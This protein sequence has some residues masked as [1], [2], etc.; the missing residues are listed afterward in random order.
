[1]SARPEI[2]PVILAGGLGRRLWPLSRPARPKPFIKISF[3]QSLLQITARRAKSFS[4]P[5]IV[6]NQKQR[7]SIVTEMR[8]CGIDPA[9]IFLE[10]CG[11]G[12][13]AAVAVVAHYRNKEN[14]L[15]L[16][17]P[18]DHEIKNPE[19]LYAAIDKGA[20]LARDGRFVLF[21]VVPQKPEKG[22]GYIR[23]KNIQDGVADVV[24]FIEKPPRKQ[25][26]VFLREGGWFWNSGIFLFSALTYLDF[27]RSHNP[28]LYQ[29]SYESVARAQRYQNSI[30]LD[31]E[32]FLACP[33]LSIDRAIMEKAR[34]KAMIP[35]DMEWRDLGSWPAFLGYLL[36]DKS[37]N[38]MDA[39][40]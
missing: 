22:F 20:P 11:R 31:K 21:G 26:R 37:K 40:E 3:G 8:G 24:S 33:N 25:A 15:F 35:V 13:A 17:M 34:H 9:Q 4:P 16:V 5:V 19:I 12:T 1:M 38:K 39:Y 29:Q 27:I 2:I 30:F 28:D 23:A 32:A 10:P 36:S 6:A 14:P 18:S 7:T